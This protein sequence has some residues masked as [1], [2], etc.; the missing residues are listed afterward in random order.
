LVVRHPVSGQQPHRHV[1][2]GP[3]RADEPGRY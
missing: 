3:Q 2:R 1:H